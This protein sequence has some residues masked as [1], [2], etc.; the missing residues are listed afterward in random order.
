LPRSPETTKE[1]DTVPTFQTPEPIS[2]NLE[3]AVA[4]IRIEASDREDTLVEVRPTD[5]AKP[6]DVTAAA[7]TR[8]EHTGGG[9][10]LKAPRRWKQYAPWRGGDSIDV[11]IDL[12]AGSAV[13]GEAGVGSLRATGELGELRFTIGV[14]EI[15]VEHA[16]RVRLRTGAGDIVID[17][18]AGDAEITT[19]SGAVE[20]G[21]VEGAA[22]IKNSNGD[23]WVGDVA[24]D[25]RASAANGT[26]AIDRPRAGVVAK[27]ANGDVRLGTVVHGQI[28]AASGR[29]GVDIGVLDGVAAWLDLDTGFGRVSNALEAAGEPADGEAVVVIRVRTGY[30]DIAIHRRVVDPVL[31]VRP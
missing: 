1:D 13:R 10:L 12:P 4:N 21:S 31:A 17:Q 15:R 19:A 28:V 23:T 5:P 14:G 3:L 16:G 27:T 11:Q 9:L 30:G 29:G 22:A 7:E 25:V 2:V 26:I 6:G 18:A 8:V 20:I 24:G